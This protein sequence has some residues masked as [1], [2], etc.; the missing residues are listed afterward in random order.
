MTGPYQLQTVHTDSLFPQNQ[1]SLTQITKYALQFPRLIIAH[2]LYE[3]TLSG[4]V[5]VCGCSVTG[6]C[7]YVY[8]CPAWRRTRVKWGGFKGVEI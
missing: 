7:R 3:L 5:H 1:H 8:W 6:V 4:S 2:I